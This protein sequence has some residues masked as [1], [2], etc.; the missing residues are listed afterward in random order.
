MNNNIDDIWGSPGISTTSYG[1]LVVHYTI[2]LDHSL[3]W[4]KIYLSYA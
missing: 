1:Y 2:G 4:V 3:I